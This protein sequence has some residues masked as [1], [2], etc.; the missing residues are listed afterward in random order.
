MILA[1]KPYRNKNTFTNNITTEQELLYKYFTVF[2]WQK[3]QKWQPKFKQIHNKKWQ[4]LMK[5]EM[6]LVGAGD[7]DVHAVTL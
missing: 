7:W 6:F 5:S 3:L 1:W 2:L 4:I